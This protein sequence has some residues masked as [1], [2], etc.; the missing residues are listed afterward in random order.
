MFFVGNNIFFAEKNNLPGILLSIDFEKAFDSL[1]WNFL[2]EALHALNFGKTFI[3]Y[4]K[5]MYNNIQSAVINNGTTCEYF[6]LQRGVRQGCP[7]SAY[8][9]IIALEILAH[10]IRSNELIK[11]F[12]IGKKE[13]KLSMLADDLTCILGNV[14]SVKYVLETLDRFKSCAGL[15]V[16]IDK[17]QA[18]YIGSLTNWDYYPHGLSWIKKPLE[19]L[20]IVLSNSDAQNY[21]ANF[22]LRIK[23]FRT[24]LN[25]WKQRNLSL[26]GKIT[27]LN[28][29]ALSSLIYVSSQTNTPLKAIQKIDSIIK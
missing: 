4:I 25:I 5:M 24:I 10:S 16:N 22:E 6:T 13:I 12:K 11:G 2:F 27:I 7:M 28:N 29:L 8:L 21:S 23:N 26:K 15:G 17:T 14:E 3:S 1:N 19:T 9:F 20:G 18:K